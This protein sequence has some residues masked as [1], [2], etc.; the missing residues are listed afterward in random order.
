[1]SRKCLGNVLRPPGVE[2]PRV[3]RVEAGDAAGVGRLV[4]P[5]KG[6]E[7][8]RVVGVAAREQRAGVVRARRPVVA[9][10]R[11]PLS[12]ETG[13][14]V[15]GLAEADGVQRAGDA[16]VPARGGAPDDEEAGG[17]VRV[18]ASG[19]SR[20]VRGSRGP[21]SGAPQRHLAPPP[22]SLRGG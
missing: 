1:M 3:E 21:L 7:L 20:A 17:P 5:S 9:R 15:V 22:L 6:P 13:G 18:L 16:A 11:L 8:A 12:F 2:P 14:G 19:D 4:E 10:L